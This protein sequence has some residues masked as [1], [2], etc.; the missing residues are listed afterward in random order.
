MPESDPSVS[1]KNGSSDRATSITGSSTRYTVLVCG[2][3]MGGEH[4]ERQQ[5]RGDG[6]RLGHGQRAPTTCSRVLPMTE[7]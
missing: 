4:H 7:V 2:T 5:H 3:R 6:Q 1:E